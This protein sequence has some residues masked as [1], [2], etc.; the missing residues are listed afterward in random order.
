MSLHVI[1]DNIA[2]KSRDSVF[3]TQPY[4]MRN[5]AGKVRY[6]FILYKKSSK[7]I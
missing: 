3:A 7:F 4:A 6:S 1:K 5:G 2:M